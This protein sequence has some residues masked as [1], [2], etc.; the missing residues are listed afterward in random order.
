[1][2]WFTVAMSLEMYNIQYDLNDCRLFIDGSERSLKA[3]LLHNESKYA[4]V[5]LGHFGYLKECYENLALI[6]TKLKCKHS[7]WT[8][9]GD[10]KL[11]SMLLGQQAGHT[12]YPCFLCEWDS[13]YKK[14]ITRQKGVA[15]E[16]SIKTWKRKCSKELFGLSQ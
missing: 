11:L 7:V 3:V 5:L 15:S 1:M 2:A 8:I 9:W 6:L 14:N 10:L 13:R 4:S 16:E 12:K